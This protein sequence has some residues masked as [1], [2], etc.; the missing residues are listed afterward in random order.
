[1][2]KKP[3]SLDYS[4]YSGGLNTKDNA[5][6][7][8]NNEAQIFK[9]VFKVQDG[10]IRRPGYK[11][12]ITGD[13]NVNTTTFGD[14][15]GMLLFRNTGFIAAENGAGATKISS[16]LRILLD[17]GE[18]IN[19]AG[20]DECYMVAANE[21]MIVANNSAEVK[22]H[23]SDTGFNGNQGLTPPT[24][25]TSALQAGGSLTSGA[26][27]KIFAGYAREFPS[28]SGQFV[29][30]SVGEALTD[31]VP[32]GGNLSIRVTIPNS[33]D[34]NSSSH[35]VFKIVWMTKGNGSTFFFAA[36]FAH[37]V[38]SIDITSETGFNESIVYGVSAANSQRP[39]GYKMIHFFDQ[40]L[41]GIDKD[42]NFI[43]RYSNKGTRFDQE[44][45]PTKNFIV[46]PSKCRLIMGL[47]DHLYFFCEDGTIRQPFGDTG[48]R[49]Q[50]VDRQIYFHHPRTVD[51][52]GANLIGWSNRGVKIFDGSNFLDVD[53]S[54]NIFD[55]LVPV[56]D[57][58][59]TEPAF[60][61]PYGM[62]VYRKERVE[63]HISWFD[64][65][66]SGVHNQRHMVLDLSNL[67]TERGVLPHW[68]EWD[69]GFN[70]AMK[71]DRISAT[72]SA[73][74]GNALYIGQSKVG[75]AYNTINRSNI[76]FEKLILDTVG[77]SEIQRYSYFDEAVFLS[78]GSFP[79]ND[80]Y[81]IKILS[82]RKL[83]G[84]DTRIIARQLRAIAAA[85][86]DFTIKIIAHNK[87]GTEV[88]KVY[89]FVA[90]SA[91]P[92]TPIEERYRKPAAMNLKGDRIS[93]E[94]EQTGLVAEDRVL[95]LINIA[96]EV[97]TVSGRL[98]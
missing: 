95:R 86:K 76:L 43:I 64:S 28:G 16:L 20:D 98:I 97:D 23:E 69:I 36:S 91:G 85:E 17:A 5:I 27:Y 39:L 83:A 26:T 29:L 31:R 61:K 35:K 22:K 87:D 84:I 47:K 3:I 55:D 38:A 33:P 21:N 12:E 11:P 60:N 6:S 70:Y 90:T 73:T 19:I 2:A 88:S 50:W 75:S 25:A 10:Y 94:F 92:T 82:K 14:L 58:M 42:D 79:A 68:E 80:F 56:Y 24:G 4:D 40:R 74:L 72:Q 66:L 89:T 78:D 9:N 37:A 49:H 18:E 71:S 34:N 41:W 81:D 51:Y 54:R 96:L 57:Q 67:F 62:V 1:M 65:D 7:I 30:F 45:W 13:G 93:I 53:L 32:S 63:Y 59:T 8:Q 77:P 48:Q 15:R 44:K 52:W 46:L